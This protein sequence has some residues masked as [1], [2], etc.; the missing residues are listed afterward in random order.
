MDLSTYTGLQ[1]AIETELNRTD[2]TTAVPAFIALM[3]AQ[4]ERQLRVREMLVTD[5]AFVVD[6]ELEDLPADFLETR[7]LYLNV[8]PVK[9]LEFRTM[10]DVIQFKRFNQGTGKPQLY[11]VIGGQ[12]MFAKAPDSAYTAT[13]VYYQK[14]PRLSVSQTSNWLLAAHPDIYFYGSLLNSAPYLKEDARIAV[15]AQL[16]QNAVEALKVADQRAQTA[17]SGLKAQARMF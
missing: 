12:F 11:T 9:P 10:E 5:T 8:N 7:N 16:Y 13:L 6:S 4:T 1:A 2:L 3:E 14:I 15:W 17:S